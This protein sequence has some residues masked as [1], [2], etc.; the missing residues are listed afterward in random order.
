MPLAK[1]WDWSLKLHLHVFLNS[2][3]F[4]FCFL[5]EAI[6]FCAGQ[7]PC[8]NGGECESTRE[9]YFCKCEVGFAGKICETSKL[10]YNKFVY[11]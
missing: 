11:K 3:S 6:D 9:G 1:K 10:L 2:F 5:G 7:N 8:Q 4:C